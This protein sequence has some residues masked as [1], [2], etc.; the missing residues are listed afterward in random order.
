MHKKKKA[1]Q[2]RIFNISCVGKGC[3]A[4]PTRLP[5]NRK[6]NYTTNRPNP[7]TDPD[8]MNAKEKKR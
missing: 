1:L 5:I 7:T 8:Q 2:P 6:P 4:I 3:G